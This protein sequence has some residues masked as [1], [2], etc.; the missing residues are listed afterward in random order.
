MRPSGAISKPDGPLRPSPTTSEV[1]KFA[2][3]AACAGTAAIVTSAGSSSSASNAAMTRRLVMAVMVPDVWFTSF[4]SP[5]M[6]SALG[7]FFNGAG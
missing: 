1:W 7:A 6:A 3:G 5:H 4:T 2:G